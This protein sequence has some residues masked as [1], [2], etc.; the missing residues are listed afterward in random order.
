[1]GWFSHFSYV[2]TSRGGEKIERQVIIKIYL[3]RSTTYRN[4]GNQSTETQERHVGGNSY[5]RLKR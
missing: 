3:N 2:R 5:L 1:M 4:T